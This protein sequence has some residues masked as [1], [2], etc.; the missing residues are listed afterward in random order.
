RTYEQRIS[1]EAIYSQA[2]WARLDATAGGNLLR[3]MGNTLQ[4]TADTLY[5]QDSSGL[6]N[7]IAC[8]NKKLQKFSDGLVWRA[9]EE[10]NLKLNKKSIQSIPLESTILKVNQYIL[11]LGE[12]LALLLRKQTDVAEIAVDPALLECLLLLNLWAISKSQPATDHIVTL[13]LAATTLQYS[14]TAE[15]SANQMPLTL[16]ALAFCFSTDTSL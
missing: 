15:A 3:E 4:E 2:H 14:L 10:R 7:E 9:Q 6:R 5:K 13:T 11:D 12:P 16:P 8:F 1:L